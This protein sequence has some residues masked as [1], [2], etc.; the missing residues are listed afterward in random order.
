M[1]QQ[2]QQFAAR[3]CTSIRRLRNQY[4]NG[5]S[6]LAQQIFG[7]NEKDDSN[8]DNASQM[9]LLIEELRGQLGT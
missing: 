8:L 9:R 1:L 7:I 2:L 4:Y 6:N 5:D 3:S